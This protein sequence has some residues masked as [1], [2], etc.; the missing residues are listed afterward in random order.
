MISL[1]LSRVTENATLI[2]VL[3]TCAS[4]WMESALLD[5]DGGQ[6]WVVYDEAWRLMSHPA[7]L[8]RMDAH[9]RLARH[10]G[11]ANML[12]FHKLSDL[13]N[14]G[15]QGSAMRALA[16]SLLAN[17]E[18]RVVYRQES[19]QLGTTAAALG[20]TGTEQS[21][22]PTLGT[23]QGLWRIKHR[24]FVVQ[25]QLHPAELE[26]FDT[27]GRMNG[28]ALDR[29]PAC[30]TTGGNPMRVQARDLAAR[31]EKLEALQQK[32][33]ESVG[34]LVTGEDWKRALE[35]AAKFRSRSLQQHDA[36]LRPALRR[37]PAGPGA[38][39]DADVRRRLPAV[40]Q[41]QPRRDEGPVR[42]RDP[43]PGHR[44]VRLLDA[45]R[46]RVVAASGPWREAR[47]RRGG[48]VEAGRPQA[49]A[50]SG[51]SPR[52]T[53]S[54]S[55][56][57]PRRRCCRARPPEGLWDGLADQ[58]TAHG[59]ELRLVS[60]AEAIGGAN[61][62]TD[63]MTREVSV[64]MDM[65]D[66]AQV[67]TLAHELGHVMLHG[68]DNADA[69]MH[70][71]IAEV[72]AESVALMVGA[73]HGLATDDYTI[74]YVS[75][76]AT[77][78][79]GKTP[80]EVVQSTAERVRGAAVTILDRLDTPQVGDGNPPGLDREALAARPWRSFRAEGRSAA[81]GGDRDMSLINAAAPYRRDD[82]QTVRV[83]VV[84][85]LVEVNVDEQGYLSVTLDR[86]PY[87]ADR[88]LTRDDL[89][90]VLD[91]IA[92]DLGTAV[93]VEVREADESTFT[94]IV[95]P[96]YRRLQVIPAGARGHYLGRR[97]GRRRVS[98]QRGGRGR[99]RGRASGRDTDGTA[100]LRL[101]PALLEAHPG[102]VVLLGKESGTVTISGGA[103]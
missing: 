16:S 70:R 9:W 81:G 71:G 101:P 97:G 46:P 32:L 25:H 3:M 50:T 41:P 33:T 43:R 85:P 67:K 54:R 69:A 14:V 96:G 63:Y 76:W 47:C 5:P 37:V 8:R 75:S 36:D 48:P 21:L 86:E 78:V 102:L 56:R 88:S 2:S 61:G 55:P 26:L 18:T 91:D 15:D 45:G 6:R 62:L 44:S 20:L 79:P 38:R 99:R 28:V 30:P 7:L 57:R 35:F 73:G 19:D 100:R 77:S 93:R 103:A 98:A 23:G 22:L 39:A 64:R 84:M 80:V 53:V 74:P 89:K 94:D 31:E 82:R 11:I 58:I 49:G 66:A 34:A 59:F 83:P 24:S 90:R 68:P 17:A 27:T 12:I 92:G 87:S 65:D 52:P 10:Y 40:A 4:A 29:T 72:E 42:L 95:T 13:D 60:N 51:T 1:D